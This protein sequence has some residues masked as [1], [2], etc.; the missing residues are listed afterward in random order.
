MPLKRYFY[1]VCLTL[2]FSLMLLP[3]QAKATLIEVSQ[4]FVFDGLDS[5]LLK[6]SVDEEGGL[7]TYEYVLTNNGPSLTLANITIDY[8]TEVSASP[9]VP[10]SNVFHISPPFV[11]GT[12]AIAGTVGI[13]LSPTLSDAG[14]LAFSVSYSGFVGQQDI[15]LTGTLNGSLI[16]QSES[17][18]Y[19][20]TDSSAPVPEPATLILLG[21]GIIGLGA[22]A[23]R[24]G[25][26]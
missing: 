4:T 6:V 24:R 9:S 8:G 11:V 16:T 26:R 10:G 7:Y 19:E 17:F 23:R 15:G 3:P 21:S 25:R 22:V 2:L 13:D 12:L 20:K 18:S 5:A 14:S 1:I